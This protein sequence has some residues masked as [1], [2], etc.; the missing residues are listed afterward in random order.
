SGRLFFVA[1]TLS[2][3]VPG[4]LNASFVALS[5]DDGATWTRREL[6]IASTCGY[7]TATQTP[8]GV[9][10]IVTSKTKP[11][12][13][14]DALNEA[15]VLQGGDRASDNQTVRDVRTEQENSPSGK[16]RAKW[17]GGIAADGNYRLDGQQIFYH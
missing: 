15:W 13:L 7:V 5:D 11:V 14:H 1:D 9:I 10:H 8:N 3:R 12:A 2:A 16:P 4:G 17:S 6:P